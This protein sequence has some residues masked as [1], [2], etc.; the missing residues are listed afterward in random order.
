MPSKQKH[1]CIILAS[2]RHWTYIGCEYDSEGKA[3][4]KK[5]TMP[6]RYKVRFLKEL[7]EDMPASNLTDLKKP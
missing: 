1:P 6:R 2:I 5:N 3:N 7:Q 4:A